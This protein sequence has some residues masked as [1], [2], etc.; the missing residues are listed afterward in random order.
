MPSR[1]ETLDLT[2]EH[3]SQCQDAVRKLTYTKWEQAG[4]PA[5]HELDFWLE[6]EREWIS[7][8]YVPN[9]PCDGARP[10]ER[11]YLLPSVPMKRSMA[12]L[13]KA[14]H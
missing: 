14:R 13:G 9:R 3:L 6:V 10:E 11:D 5:G 4:C 8:C 2:P 12:C 1:L 7:H